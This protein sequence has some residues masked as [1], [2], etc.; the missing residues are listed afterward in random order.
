MDGEEKEWRMEGIGVWSVD[1]EGKWKIDQPGARPSKKPAAAHVVA[2][3]DVVVGRKG[4]KDESEE[5]SEG[6]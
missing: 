3:K 4:W 2:H 1:E 6:L 5:G